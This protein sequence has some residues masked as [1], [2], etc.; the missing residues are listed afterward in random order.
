MPNSFLHGEESKMPSDFII[1]DG[2]ERE[3]QELKFRVEHLEATL[4]SLTANLK[5]VLDFYKVDTC[6]HLQVDSVPA[7]N[8]V[9]IW[10][11]GEGTFRTSTHACFDCK[12]N[13][14]FKHRL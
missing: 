13:V 8:S 4:Q 10:T 9:Q 12:K 6:K 1:R 14:Q 5:R 3:V 2:I 7:P 11:T